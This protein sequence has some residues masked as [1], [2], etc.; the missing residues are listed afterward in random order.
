MNG[1]CEAGKRPCSASGI[2]ELPLSPHS[3]GG[4]LQISKRKMC[5]KQA[6]LNSCKLVVCMGIKLV[7][8]I[9]YRRPN[10]NAASFCDEFRLY[11][12]SI[13]TVGSEVFVCGD[14]NFWVDDM[15]NEDANGFIETMDILGYKN[16]VN[17][18]TSRT[19]HMLVLV[20]GESDKDLIQ[21]VDVDDIY[22]LY[23]QCIWLSN[24]NLKL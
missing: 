5:L 18:I 23:L 24:L 19:G 17:K 3:D 16:W 13:D 20:F 7:F 8:I 15:G 12:E 6:I 14:F 2:A 21:S 4:N 1:N 10:S 11:L 9:V 22:V